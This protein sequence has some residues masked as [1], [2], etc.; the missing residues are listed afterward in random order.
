MNMCI[1][2]H[3]TNAELARAVDECYGGLYM[4]VYVYMYVCIYTCIFEGERR[5]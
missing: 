4:F 3:A 2:M 1:C 5:H